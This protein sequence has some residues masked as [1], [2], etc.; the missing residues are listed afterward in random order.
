MFNAIDVLAVPSRTT[1]RWKEQFGRVIIEAHACGTPVIGSNS[2]AIPDVIGGA[3]LIVPE[4]DPSALADAIRSLM[5]GP[6]QREAMGQ[7]GLQAAGT[8]YT[9]EA[10][11]KCMHGI[12]ST[13]LARGPRVGVTLTR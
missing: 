10:V 12:Y 3:G 9:W 11:A 2:G 7:R 13:L 4:R 8:Q 1:P 5:Q 6:T